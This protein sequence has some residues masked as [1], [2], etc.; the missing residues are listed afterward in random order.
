MDNH[1]KNQP[2]ID[3]EEIVEGILEWVEIESPSTDKMAVN[4]MAKLVEAQCLSAGLTVERTAGEEGWG[5]LIR[6]RAPHPDQDIPGILILS[7]IDT[8]H[9]LGTKEGDNP[10]RREADKLYGPGIYDMKAG[11]YLAYYA[12][13]HLLR[14]GNS[15]KLPVTFMFVPEEEVGSPYSRKYIEE[16]AA[17]AKYVLVTEPARD[18]GKIVVARKGWG[19]FQLKTTGVPAHAGAKHEDGRSA[20][21]E[22]AR[23]ILDI[24]AMTDYE[25]GISLNVG[26][27]EGGTGTNVVPR[28]CHINVDMR[29]TTVQDGEEMVAVM[30]GLTAYDPDVTLTVGG[31]MN[32]PPFEMNDATA[33][34]FDIARNASLE[35]GLDLQYTTMT[36]GCSDGNFTGAMGVPTL[37]GMGADGAGAHTLD[38]FILISSLE[39]RAKTWVKLLERLE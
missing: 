33:A 31:G 15:P 27:I 29:V 22:M 19:N 23:Q 16:E 6:A 24:E 39:P 9:P 35:H 13:R 12:Y 10:I 25:R 28:E 38:E 21:K 8:V 20:I 5:D 14:Q 32:R 4:E 1:Q 11:A 3:P 2:L 30:H 18:G 7:H 26:L 36:G 37:D 17:K 34:L